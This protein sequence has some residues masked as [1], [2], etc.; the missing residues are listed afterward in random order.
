M[1]YSQLLLNGFGCRNKSFMRYFTLLLL[2]L[3]FCVSA[4]EINVAV[5]SNFT[6]AIKQIVKQFE[7]ETGYKVQLSIASSG[8]HYAQIRFGAPFDVF[9]SADQE[10]PAA[11]EKENLIVEGSRFT[12]ALGTLVLVANSTSEANPEKRLKADHYGRLAIANPKLAPYGKAASETLKRLN[13]WEN[14][15]SKRVVG[16]N[17]AQTYQFLSS[18]N[19]DLAFIS[20]SQLIDNPVNL[21]RK[22]WVVPKVYYSPIRQ[23][24]V[25]LNAAASNVAARDFLRY[26]QAE[27]AIEII[28][29]YGYEVLQQSDPSDEES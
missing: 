5:A 21:K 17:V 29:S 26:L 10:K 25:L 8:K 4:A 15:Q 28:R 22:A 7:T 27:Q 16:E 1:P 9:L 13:L 12:Y 2:A 18:G 19:V 3:P 23:D 24:A 6:T 11:L 20:S 14:S